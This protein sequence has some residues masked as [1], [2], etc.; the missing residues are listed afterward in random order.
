MNG[1]SLISCFMKEKEYSV[2]KQEG[3]IDDVINDNAH[4]CCHVL[5][6]IARGNTIAQ[7][8]KTFQELLDAWSFACFH[9]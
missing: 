4:A 2:G 5:V 6:D 3:G 8:N 7:N 1:M 9:L